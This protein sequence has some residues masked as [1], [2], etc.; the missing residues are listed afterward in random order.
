MFHWRWTF[1]FVVALV[2]DD[3]ISSQNCSTKC[4]CTK[5]FTYCL[6]QDITSEELVNILP[7]IPKTTEKL[8]LG[9]N[10][11][12]HVNMEE[13]SHLTKLT[14]LSLNFNKLTKLP[15]RIGHFLP[16]LRILHLTANQI[17]TISSEN[18]RNYDNLRVLNL[19]QNSIKVIGENTFDK[20]SNLQEL[21]L[22]QNQIS[23]I[24]QNTFNGLRNLIKL[25]LSDNKIKT[26]HED[27][28][29][30]TLQLQELYL[31]VN[32]ITHIPKG[33]FYRL[34]KLRI[35]YLS[36]NFIAH[37]E[38]GAFDGLRLET[39]YL[40]LNLLEKL[41]NNLFKNTDIIR[42]VFLLDN[43]FQCSC[44]L[45]T[46]VADARQNLK[47]SRHK[48][49]FGDC[50][51]HY[52]TIMSVEGLTVESL[53]CTACDLNQCP[54]MTNCTLEASEKDGYVCMKYI[55][56]LVD[57]SETNSRHSSSNAQKISS[58]IY[59]IVAVISILIVVCLIIAVILFIKSRQK[60]KAFKIDNK[61]IYE[62]V[63]NKRTPKLTNLKAKNSFNV[64]VQTPVR[65]KQ[66][67]V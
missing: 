15:D 16:R 45:A 62:Q 33:L 19:D 58:H 64:V 61:Y 43:P 14:Y 10:K 28:F 20:M 29:Q 42:N 18:L 30:S 55:G 59:L 38:E 66:Y 49:H 32:K 57:Q 31:E 44:Q 24:N 22:G 50:K 53:N 41:P 11:I 52:G 3:V 9:G 63:D 37:I 48:V 46:A 67:F 12:T 25:Q 40:N 4:R 23:D 1:V 27:V 7:T 8:Y 13:F 36:D 26:I 39:V 34:T 17:K 21:L 60:R 65:M 2:I 56:D 5:T 35:I 54:L 6:Y 47:S 51:L